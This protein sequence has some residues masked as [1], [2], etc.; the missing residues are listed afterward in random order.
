MA[1]ALSKRLA[2]L[3]ELLSDRLNTPVAVRWFDADKQSSEQVLD[4]MVASGEIAAADRGRVKLVRWLTA[5]EYEA[6]KP[7]CTWAEEIGPPADTQDHAGQIVRGDAHRSE[8]GATPVARDPGAEDRYR[9]A[10][11]RREAELVQEKLAA[12]ARLFARSI[13]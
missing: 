1:N 11:K 7:F 2:R 12:A 9:E 6:A 5:A 10:V 13:V 3:E 4:A 8:A